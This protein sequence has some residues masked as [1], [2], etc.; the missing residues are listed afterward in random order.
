MGRPHPDWA[1]TLFTE[2]YKL[3]RVDRNN[4]A[5]MAL[6]RRAFQLFVERSMVGSVVGST[7]GSV[8]CSVVSSMVGSVVGSMVG[9]MVGSVVL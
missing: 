3:S 7:V 4:V 8:V 5:L 6:D 9:S 2:I 1:Q